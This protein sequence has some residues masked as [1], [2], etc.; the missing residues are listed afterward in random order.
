[1]A[2]AVV[3]AVAVA[4]HKHKNG[5][6]NMS[7]Y[8]KPLTMA[9]NELRKKIEEAIAE[10][11]LPSC[12]VEPIVCNYW[13]QLKASAE[14]QARAEKEKFMKEEEEEFMKKA[15]EGEEES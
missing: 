2:S 5:G 14:A 9:L 13:L 8:S 11:N 10:S 6:S 3:V 12:I 4:L 1:M 7:K 15:K